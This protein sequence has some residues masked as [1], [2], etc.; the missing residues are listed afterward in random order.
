MDTLQK[1]GIKQANIE[2]TAQSLSSELV[3][4]RWGTKASNFTNLS[5]CSACDGVFQNS[6]YYSY[7]VRCHSNKAAIKAGRIYRIFPTPA[8]V[9]AG[10]RNDILSAEVLHRLRNNSIGK[11]CRIDHL[12]KLLS[13]NIYLK[14]CSK[15][16]KKTDGRKCTVQDM[17]TLASLNL[18][19][20]NAATQVQCKEMPT[21]TI[22]IFEIKYKKQPLITCIGKLTVR[23]NKVKKYKSFTS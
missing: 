18:H 4:E 23:Q 14:V 12:I 3:C 8:I 1:Q 21:S 11:L 16:L 19:L 6:Y 7:R 15:G 9:L 10:E 5:T 22:S 2:I 17:R 20:Q 13:K